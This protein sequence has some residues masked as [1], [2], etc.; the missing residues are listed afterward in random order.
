LGLGQLARRN[1]GVS[2]DTVCNTNVTSA[3]YSGTPYRKDDTG[4]ETTGD[5]CDSQGPIFA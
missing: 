2:T 1:L 5:Y 3:T 4:A